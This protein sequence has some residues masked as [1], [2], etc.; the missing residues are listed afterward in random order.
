[1]RNRQRIPG[2]RFPFFLIFSC[3]FVPGWTMNRRIYSFIVS[4]VGMW[5]KRV[6]GFNQ[7]ALTVKVVCSRSQSLIIFLYF[8]KKNSFL[9]RL[10]SSRLDKK[11][12]TIKRRNRTLFKKTFEPLYATDRPTD[13]RRTNQAANI[14]IIISQKE[15]KKISHVSTVRWDLSR[16][17]P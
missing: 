15:R 17:W 6:T 3:P 4:G 2:S 16:A 9:S 5:S 8:K 12:R 7:F 14:I 10:D 1:M 13:R 11:M